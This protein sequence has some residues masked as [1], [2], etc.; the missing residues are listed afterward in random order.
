MPIY[1]PAP[2]FARRGGHPN[3]MLVLVGAHVAVIAAVMSAKMDLPTRI[4]DPPI[5]IEPIAIPEPTLPVEPPPPAADPR[6]S[7]PVIDQVPPL[8]PVPH[9]EPQVERTPVPPPPIPIPGGGALGAGTQPPP[10]LPP[11]PPQP[12]VDPVRTGPRFLTPAHL[13]E[14]PYPAS[15][16]RDEEEA[17]LRLRLSI[18]QRGRVVAVEPVGS[19]DRIF[20]QAARRHV[21]ANWRY[22]P[23][24][25]GGKPVASSTVMTLR[26]TLKD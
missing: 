24:M 18:D 22:R 9:T 2:A 19:V 15:K 16:L 10:P 26:F 25:E 1:A 17:A 6:P 21:L 8:V 4:F 23:A 7:K 14:P 13:I 20:F 12:R 11:P 5:V 3:A